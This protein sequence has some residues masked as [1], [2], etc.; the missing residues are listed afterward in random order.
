MTCPRCQAPSKK[1]ATCADCYVES[2][3]QRAL[4][5]DRLTKHEIDV[6]LRACL[7]PAPGHIFVACD[8]SQV[9]ARVL[10]WAADDLPAVEAFLDNDRG[11]PDPYCRLAGRIFG[12]D[13]TEIRD[14]YKADD[15]LA[16]RQRDTGKKGELGC[17]YGMGAKKFRDTARKGGLDWDTC[18]KANGSLLDPKEV[19]DA[20]RELHA[21]IVS[22]WYELAD[23]VMAATGG[24]KSDVGPFS[25]GQVD[26][27]V[28]IMLPSGR[29]IVYPRARV[30][31]ETDDNGKRRPGIVF[32]G[33][34]TGRERTYG[35]K[36]TENV[37]QGLC[38]DLLAI[39]L[40]EC[41]RVGLPVALHTHDE[42]VAEV[43]IEW[44][45]SACG[46]IERIFLT[47]PPWAVGCP[48]NAKAFSCRR[49]RK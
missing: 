40:V 48:I 32:A 18:F 10:A 49:Y 28:W 19:V 21:P 11:G 2:I 7:V 26:E 24:A 31:Y 5:R 38:R 36:L 44:A 14:A 9:E 16:A 34:K 15:P 17:G 25:V 23:A 12:R 22:F 1:D 45:E 29:P 41:E 30:E 43:P 39:S 37:I 33:G 46:E 8:Y 4:A 20:W 6:A 47:V 35:G 13:A 42:A 27:D 3:C